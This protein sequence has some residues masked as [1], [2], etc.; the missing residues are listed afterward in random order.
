MK[1]SKLIQY[2]F[3]FFLLYALW[4]FIFTN[5]II[6]SSVFVYA[7]MAILAF[8]FGKLLLCKKTK[9]LDMS[10]KIWMP[11]LFLTSFCWFL[12]FKLEFVVYLFSCIAI[13]ILPSKVSIQD[14][15]PKKLLFWGG[16]FA[17]VGIIVQMLMPSLYNSYVLPLF[18]N[19]DV[20][21]QWIEKEYGFAGF[22]YQLAATANI[23][24]AAEAVWLYCRKD[25]KCNKLLY[26]SILMIFILGVFL[27]GKRSHSAMSVV[28]PLIVYLFSRKNICRSIASIIFVGIVGIIAVLFF[29]EHSTEYSDSII[30][31]RFASSVENFQ[32]GDDISSGRAEL[33]QEALKMSGSL[34]GIGLGNFKLSSK[35]DM[36]AH[37]TYYQVLCEQGIIG[38][39]L[40]VI[41]IIFCLIRTIKLLRLYR[42]NSDMLKLSLFWQMYFILYS[43]TGNTMNDRANYFFYFFAIA[44]FSDIRLKGDKY[45]QL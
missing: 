35:F 11:F 9:T 23:L 14:N 29:M 26:C 25:F 2:T 36:D 43:F 6:A 1:S 7:S 16:I 31:R 15:I 39:I 40:F 27:T 38:F 44:L 24:L 33:G 21:S 37:Q 18:I 32:S 8:T 20:L 19:N 12:K 34:F 28:I 22:T 45:L 41:P 4:D 10:A 42:G 30:L 3:S 5:T 13:L 17:F